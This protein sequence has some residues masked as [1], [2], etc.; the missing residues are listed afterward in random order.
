MLIRTVRMTFQPEN[1]EGFLEIFNNSKTKIR[2]FKG[3]HHLELWQDHCQTNIFTTFSY[4]EDEAALDQYRESELFKEVWGQ[5]KVLFAEKPR[6]LSQKKI[7]EVG[8]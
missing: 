6:A 3:C 2:G 5:T 4:W 1:V 7:E 8:L